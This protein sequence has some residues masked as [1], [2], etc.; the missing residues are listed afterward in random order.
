MRVCV[1]CGSA[2]GSNPA[3]AAAA[4]RLGALLAGHGLGLV[5]GGGNI[6]LMGVL[7]DTVM[8]AGGNV[9]GV[10]PRNLVA[11]EIGHTGIT[12]L[13]IVETMHQRK[14]MMADLS[15]AFLALPGGYGTFDE[16][17]EAVTWT[18]LGIHRKACGLLNVDGY[19]DP[20]IAML[21]R[22]AAD[23]FILP[24]NRHLVL[25]G[26]DPDALLRRLLRFKPSAPSLSL[27][28]ASR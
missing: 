8:A 7:A 13:R 2:T 17:F 9:I 23:G 28:P 19:F 10:M 22:A 11:R 15:D 6:G 5:Y 27:D 26:H 24:H 25:A 14:A 1:F 18:Q 20:L 3:Y 21:D 16:F 4:R 12:D